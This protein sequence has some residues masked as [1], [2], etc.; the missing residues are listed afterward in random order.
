MEPLGSIFY[1]VWNQAAVEGGKLSA[2]GDGQREEIAVSHLAG[3]KQA[4]QIEFPGV[5]EADIVGPEVVIRPGN[6][7]SHAL[8]D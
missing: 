3:V 1:C 4:V 6:E 7:L 5:Q 8:R 2:V